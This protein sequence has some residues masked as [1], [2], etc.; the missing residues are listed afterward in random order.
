MKRNKLVLVFI[1]S[2]FLPLFSCVYSPLREKSMNGKW[3]FSVGDNV[4]WSKAEF[5]DSKWGSIRVPGTWDSD[6]LIEYNGYVWYRNHFRLSTKFKSIPLDL[7]IDGVS[8]PIEV[9]FNG[10]LIGK[11]VDL[12]SDNNKNRGSK[13]KYF[14][15]PT[16]IK[17]DNI[18]AIRM[19]KTNND[20]I[21]G[22]IRLV[23]KD[24][25]PID[26]SLEGQW[27]FN[28]KDNMVWKNPEF[29]DADWK[30]LQVPERIDNQGYGDYDGY[31]W[32]RKKF[33]LSPQLRGKKLVFVLG[34]ID[35]VD[36]AFI[37]GE[38][39]GSTGYLTANSDT[40][41][42]NNESNV[43]RGYYVPDNITLRDTGNVI[44]VRVFDAHG[45]AGMYEGPIGIITQESYINYWNNLHRRRR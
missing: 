29:N 36:Q 31:F 16:I 32:Y 35:D 6:G 28:I 14:V 41:N 3:K 7:E 15:S 40:I 37:N 20:E 5:D 11:S 22:N 12:N 10:F 42:V 17:V 33:D 27:K 39:I 34:K 2:L 19:Y 9:Y 43:F 21:L 13:K 18:V 4:Q 45:D 25:I 30:L 26:Q 1:I 24:D 44:A 8:D 38:M 23:M